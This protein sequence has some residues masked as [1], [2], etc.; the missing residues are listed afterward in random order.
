M[1]SCSPVGLCVCSWKNYPNESF[2]IIFS[3]NKLLESSS[4][5]LKFKLWTYFN[6]C[7]DLESRSFLTTHMLNIF[8]FIHSQYFYERI[9]LFKNDVMMEH[10]DEYSRNK[11][12]K[13]GLK[14]N[15]ASKQMILVIWQNVQLW[16][17]WLISHV[18]PD[19]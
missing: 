3:S 6:R 10:D 8:S 18:D 14:F 16:P 2:R 13:K 11:W 9:T 19:W 12:D 4:I 17:V 1:F 5:C 7:S 15:W